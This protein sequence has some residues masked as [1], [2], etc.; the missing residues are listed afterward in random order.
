MRHQQRSQHHHQQHNQQR[1]PRPDRQQPA[2]SREVRREFLWRERVKLEMQVQA[3]IAQSELLSQEWQLL[4]YHKV[5]IEQEK[6][7]LAGQ[8]ILSGLAGMRHLPA[9]R[10]HQYKRERVLQEE[11]RLQQAM[12]QC[13]SDRAALFAQIEV[14][15]VE[16]SLL[17]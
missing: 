8:I 15:T 5:R 16:L 17:F 12:L 7:K 13:E 11:A 9:E 10:L 3:I 4:Q 14:I 2:T 6:P 1:Q